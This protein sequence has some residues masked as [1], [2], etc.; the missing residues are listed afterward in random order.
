[1]HYIQGTNRA[2]I[3]LFSHIDDWVSPNNPVRL[4][5]LLV[6]KIVLSNPDKFI[7]KGKENKGRKAFSPETML[8]LYLYGYLN[9][10]PSSRRLEQETYRN[11]ELMWLLQE[12][13]PDFWTINEYRKRNKEHIRFVT[14]EFRKFLKT[15]N[16]ITGKEVV[17]DGSKFKAYASRDMLS[18]KNIKKRL[19]S[20]NKKLDQYIEEL[21]VADTVEELKEEFDIDV[22]IDKTLISKIADLQEQVAKLEEQ[23]RILE[24]QGKNYLAPNDHDAN[25][26]KSR[27]GK[28]AAYNGQTI[29]DQEHKMLALAEI[30]T[31]ENDLYQLKP[32]LNKLDEQLDIVPEEIDADAGFVNYKDIKEIEENTKTKCYVPNLNNNK[33]DKEAGLKFTYDKKN[34]EYVCPQGKKLKIRQRNRLIRRKKEGY[35]YYVNVYECKECKNCPIKGKCTS[36]KK[37]R[38]ISRHIDQEWIDEYQKRMSK[39]YA[40]EK[41]KKR[42]TVV[43]HPFG[44]IKWMMGLHHFLLTGKDKVQTELDLYATVYNIKRLIN[45]DNMQILLNKVNNYSW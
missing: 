33:K 5:D 11:I 2:E 32:N 17:T 4:I 44:I 35:S 24:E 1:M 20:V 28:M 30:V 3:K 12:L 26:M 14:I 9:K 10:I 42:K 31:D 7:W 25:L 15:E 38:S 43:E 36:S 13:H 19:E 21:K 41:I 18:L 16:Y 8:K 39:R 29:I 34:D 40:K 6:D 45:I 37:G 23:K 27:Q 22:D